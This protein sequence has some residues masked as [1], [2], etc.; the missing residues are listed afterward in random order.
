[1]C[2]FVPT[3]KNNTNDNYYLLVFIIFSYSCL[4]RKKKILG[5][6]IVLPAAFCTGINQNIVSLSF[7]QFSSFGF[8]YQNF[9]S[10]QQQFNKIWRKRG[11]RNPPL[12]PQR[13]NWQ[14]I[15]QI[16]SKVKKRACQ[17]VKHVKKFFWNF[18]FMLYSV[19]KSNN[20][21]WYS[22]LFTVLIVCDNF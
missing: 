19:P 14:R 12:P 18:S 15:E 20:K 17:T 13:T 8:P 5:Y 9:N 21:N 16:K 10:W 11:A 7:Y 22:E 6:N 2:F 1:M 4:F 3:A